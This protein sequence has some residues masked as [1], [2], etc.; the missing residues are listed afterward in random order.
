MYLVACQES[1]TYKLYTKRDQGRQE[2]E[3]AQLVLYKYT[4]LMGC[5]S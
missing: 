2:N 3:V 5:P 1:C 4:V